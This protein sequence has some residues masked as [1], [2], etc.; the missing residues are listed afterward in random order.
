MRFE[1]EKRHRNCKAALEPRCSGRG[2]PSDQGLN[3]QAVCYDTFTKIR[4]LKGAVG[5]D[6]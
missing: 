6:R 3:A 5:C 2:G 4:G 1:M